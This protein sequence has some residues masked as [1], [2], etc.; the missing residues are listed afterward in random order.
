MGIRRFTLFIGFF[1]VALGICGFIPPLNWTPWS[2]VVVHNTN[3][4][5][6]V[7]LLFGCLPVT[8]AANV[9]HLLIGLGGLLAGA[10]LPTAQKYCQGLAVF[11]GMLAVAGCLPYGLNTLWGYLPL[12]GGEMAIHLITCPTAFYFGWVATF[13]GDAGEVELA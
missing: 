10:K 2:T 12:S 6:T 3:S 13:E 4:P 9:L 1:Y 8:V 5:W 11:T 7:H